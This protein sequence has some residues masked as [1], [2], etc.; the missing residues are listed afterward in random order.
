MNSGLITGLIAGP[1]RL[2]K[3]VLSRKHAIPNAEITQALANLGI[4]R[5][6][7]SAPVTRTST[8]TLTNTGLTALTVSLLPSSRYRLTYRLFAS[9]GAGFQLGFTWPSS[10]TQFDGYA[11][12]QDSLAGLAT[13]IYADFANNG[14]ASGDAIINA[15]ADP[16]QNGGMIF[17]A[18]I[19]TS[20]T[21][22]TYGDFAVVFAQSSSNASATTMSRNSCVEV[23]KF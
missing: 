16:S 22:N 9:G 21:A 20:S 12:F 23:L 4:A 2:S 8:T 13:Y 15:M 1:N 14:S 3:A 11:T 19:T 5:V 6:S 18:D 7:L 17:V 10:L